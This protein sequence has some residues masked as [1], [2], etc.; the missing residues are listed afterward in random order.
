M[1]SVLEGGRS[2]S[3]DALRSYASSESYPIK[4]PVR[5]SSQKQ[6]KGSIFTAG[7]EAANLEVGILE[8]CGLRRKA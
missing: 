3:G 4:I 6:I 8:A 5:Y 2:P 1:S 7:I